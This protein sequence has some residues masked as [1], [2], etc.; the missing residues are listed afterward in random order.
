V[1]EEKPRTCPLL[2]HPVKVEE[3]YGSP[4]RKPQGKSQSISIK[5]RKIPGEDGA[6]TPYEIKGS[7][8]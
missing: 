3:N 7:I 4:A 1:T 5:A 6:E 8:G 2:Y